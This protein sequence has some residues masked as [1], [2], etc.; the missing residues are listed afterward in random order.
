MTAAPSTAR[1]ISDQ[2]PKAHFLHIGKTG[3]TAIKRA[4]LPHVDEGPFRI[5]L[6]PHATRLDHVPRGEC[7]FFLLRDPVTRFVSGFYSRQRQGKPRYDFPWSGGEAS[8]YSCFGTANELAEAIDACDENRRQAAQAALR[9]ILHIRNSVW[10]WFRDAD[11]FAS[12]LDDIL[13]VGLQET[14]NR[15]FATLRGILGLGTDVG[16]PTN[17]LESH[18]NPDGLDLFLSERARH[19]LRNHYSAD[20]QFYSLMRDILE[21]IRIDEINDRSTEPGPDRW[22]LYFRSAWAAHCAQ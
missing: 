9:E 1:A 21:T 13:F 22:N 10:S 5:I 16:L 18:K 4:L 3:G 8:A 15:D 7:V 6:H 11:Y 2:K 19:N 20:I 14:L 12:R 17:D